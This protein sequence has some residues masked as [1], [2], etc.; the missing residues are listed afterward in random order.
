MKEA[1]MDSA[2][3][4]GG[5]P[6]FDPTCGKTLWEESIERFFDGTRVQVFCCAMCRRIYIDA[7]LERSHAEE[8]PSVESH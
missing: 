6:H 2:C 7:W 4:V 3:E 8:N 1:A 5:P